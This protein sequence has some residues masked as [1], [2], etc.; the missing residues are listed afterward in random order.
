MG[1]FTFINPAWLLSCYQANEISID[2]INLCTAE[3]TQK[4]H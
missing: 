1:I 3:K 4:L 2:K